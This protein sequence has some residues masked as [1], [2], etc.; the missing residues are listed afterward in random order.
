MNLIIQV[1]KAVQETG[2]VSDQVTKLLGDVQTIISELSNT[3][4]IDEDTL[5]RL[6]KE[7]EQIET[8]INETKLED[9]VQELQQKHKIQASLITEYN[10]KIEELERDVDNIKSIVESLPDGCFRRLELEP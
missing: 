8:K 2:K 7:I 1:G 4:D 6:D 3:P 5:D 10:A 9:R